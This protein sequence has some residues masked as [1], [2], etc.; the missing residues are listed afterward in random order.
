MPTLSLVRIFITINRSLFTLAIFI[1]T[2]QTIIHWL[3]SPSKQ[4]ET[5]TQLPSFSATL[6]KIPLTC[7]IIEIAGPNLILSNANGRPWF[8]SNYLKNVLPSHP[9]IFFHPETLDP[10]P[11]TNSLY[12]SKRFFP[13]TLLKHSATLPLSFFHRSTIILPLSSKRSQ[14]N[15]AT[16]RSD[17][18]RIII[19]QTIINLNH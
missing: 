18:T 13:S 5:R 2:T 19:I 16:T 11:R 6:H 7:W 17:L 15:I 9:S 12:S 8:I 1:Y 4:T 14:N 10:T 3:I